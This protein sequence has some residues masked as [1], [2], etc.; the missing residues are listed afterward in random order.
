VSRS[1]TERA[2]LLSRP[3]ASYYLVL[4]STFLLLALGLVMVLS[5]SSVTSYAASGSSFSIVSK[6]ATWAVVGIPTFYAASRLPTRFFRM[7]GYPLLIASIGLLLLVPLIGKSVYGATRWLDFG[8]IQI[9][10]SELAKLAL[11]LWG[12]DLFA[13]KQRLLGD[14]RHLLVPFLP[15]LAFVVLLV[16]LGNDL[17]S[18]IILLILGFALLWTV[19]APGRIMGLLAAAGVA[20]VTL[21]A[22]VEPYR[23][24]R[25]TAFLH[26]ERDPSGASYQVIQGLYGLASGR[27][28]G[29]GL[30]ASRQKWQYLPNAY[31][32]F[33]FSIIGEELG[34]IGCLAVLPLFATMAYA[35]VRIA[36]R[37]TDPFSRLVAGAV[38]TWMLGQAI[39]NMA[40]VT[41]L[42]PVTGIT[43]PLVSFG[44][45]S[46]VITLFALG[47][48]AGVA[49]REPEAAQAL[50]AR[51]SL[52]SRLRRRPAYPE[53]TGQPSSPRRETAPVTVADR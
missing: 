26:P 45:T 37:A 47:I 50:A 4:G 53:P 24:R 48:L 29:V 33:I 49:R 11:L 39:I 22:I 16:M 6:Q 3:L 32:D 51:G 42:L 12:A 23:L 15:V 7:L 27:W 28:F 38:T 43:L 2:P 40:A 5:A 20:G 31:T 21:L 10:P 13:R 52:V 30:G 8:P 25:L 1:T 46:L 36:R 9:Q 17:G 34:L 35:G 44:G 14:W 18:T 19:G 41:T